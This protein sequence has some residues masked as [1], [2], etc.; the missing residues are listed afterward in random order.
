MNLLLLKNTAGG[1]A[2]LANGRFILEGDR[3]DDSAAL[4]ETVGERFAAALE[5]GLTVREF[6]AGPA[7][8]WT[9]ESM[10]AQVAGSDKS[11]TRECRK[12]GS[13]L[14]ADSLCPD[15]TCPYSDWPQNVSL[16]DMHALD[17]DAICAKY[18][19]IR[20]EAHSDDRVIEAAFEA[21][22]WFITASNADILELV[23]EEWGSCEVADAVALHHETSPKLRLLFDY[24]HSKNA[25]SREIG[26]ECSVNG[27]DAMAWLR[28][29]RPG[30]WA[31]ILCEREGVRF[32][33]AEEEEVRGLWDW[34]GPHGNACDHSFDSLEA[35]AIDAL[36]RLCLHDGNA[37]SPA[38]AA[39]WS[40][41]AFHS[42]SGEDV[43]QIV[44][45]AMF[46][47]E[48]GYDPDDIAGIAALSVGQSWESPDYGYAH[49]VRRIA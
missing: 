30:L 8:E 7:A 17:A 6:T 5:T 28:C 24:I 18:G 35:A 34:I 20:A 1:C 25:V 16:D 37:L 40:V 10:A 26:F 44:G 42:P 12:C 29:A 45:P 21:H 2:L 38:Y 3:E 47:D 33:Q 27:D 36:Q 43:R 39:F 15:L 4:V 32:T 23:A 41:D 49:T 9:W 19:L 11:A 14:H 22:S 31:R 46:C 13:K 48:L